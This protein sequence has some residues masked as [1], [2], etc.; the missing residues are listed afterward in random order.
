MSNKGTPFFI[1]LFLVFILLLYTYNLGFPPERYF[2]EVYHAR[3]ASQLA[4]EGRFDPRSSTHPP[5]WHYAGALAIKCFGNFPYIWRIPSVVC[6]LI[7]IYLVYM[8]AGI[9][10]PG[11]FIAMCAA[12]LFALDG[13]SLTQARISMLNSMTLMFM[14][15][16]VIC[17]LKYY[18]QR[19]W[20]ARKG[21]MWAGIFTGLAM[22]T[23]LS[24]VFILILFFGIFLFDLVKGQK[25]HRFS[26]FQFLLYFCFIPF[27]I[28]M[29]VYLLIPLLG[30]ASF[31]QLLSHFEWSYKGLVLERGH[32]YGS[33][34]WSW[35]LML[36]P[37]WYYYKNIDGV[38]QGILCIGNPAVFWLIPGAFFVTVYKLVRQ[39]IW[40]YGFILLM[41]LTQWLP[42]AL[43][44][45]VQF[46]HYFY[47]VMPAACMMIALL[48]H[49]LWKDASYGRFLAIVYLGC[50]VVMFIYWYPL[51]NGTPIPH[52]FYKSHMWF[53]PWI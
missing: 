17:F 41:F 29:F 37:I 15:L 6:G 28:F 20:P 22:A 43:V 53:R 10:F 3:R 50:V 34:W 16:S 36:R 51:L 7:N 42:Y 24:S 14:L 21:L 32:R 1:S 30:L 39:K 46:F 12:V 40:G 11:R 26:I 19:H 48:L 47:F 52:S 23:K 45:R 13:M 49:H 5:L 25:P 44:S 38:V 27:F 4:L 33:L 31:S 35:P 9:L 18:Y 8:L 2:D